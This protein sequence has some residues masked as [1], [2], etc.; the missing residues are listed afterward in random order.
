MS[1]ED[2]KEAGFLMSSVIPQSLIDK[3]EKDVLKA[4]IAP[5]AP[6]ADT[7]SDGVARDTLM[8][9]VELLVKQRS[10]FATRSGAKEKNV[11]QSMSANDWAI[12]RQHAKDCALQLE[13]LA[14]SEGVY[15]WET[16]VTDIC[17]ILFRTNYLGL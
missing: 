10:I 1:I 3:A 11:P 2:Y 8:T 17:N 7:A 12:L 15:E 13:L 5:I 6:D 4:Y 16:K 9:L 14:K